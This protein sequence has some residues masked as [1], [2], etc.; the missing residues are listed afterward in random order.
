MRQT[1][2]TVGH[3]GLTNAQ[4]SARKMANKRLND[5]DH[6]GLNQYQRW[7]KYRIKNNIFDNAFRKALK[8]HNFKNTSLIYQGSYEK[9][10]LEQLEKQ[11]SIEWLKKNVKRGPKIEYKDENGYSRWYISDYIIG[12]TVYEI[13]SNWTF[14]KRGKDLILEQKNIKKLN[15]TKN[16]GYNVILV[17]E[18]IQIEY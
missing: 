14:N 17:K 7:T 12:N 15:A 9:K 13:K 18:G 3:D 11:H 10:F 8:I 16:K 1:K 6:N 4:R 5:I 2:L